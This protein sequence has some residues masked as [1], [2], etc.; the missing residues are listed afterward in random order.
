M[1]SVIEDFEAKW[2]FI[3]FIVEKNTNLVI[4]KATNLVMVMD[5]YNSY[6]YEQELY[7]ENK[8]K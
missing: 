2:S 4:N 8:G 6:V 7:A 1:D 5:R 3:C